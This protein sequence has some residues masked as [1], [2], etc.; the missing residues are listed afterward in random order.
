M[1]LDVVTAKWTGM[2]GGPGTST[3]YLDHA[4][5]WTLAPVGDFFGLLTALIPSTCTITMA[6][7][8]PEIDPVTGNLIGAWV[9]AAT[10]PKVGTHTGEYAS[11][12]GASVRWETG[13]IAHGHRVRGRTYLVPLASAVF[14]IDGSID[15]ASLATIKNSAVTMLA[16]LPNMVKVWHRPKTLP[17]PRPGSSHQVSTAAV[18]DRCAILRSRRG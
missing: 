2:P 8:G 9:R 7:E 5:A 12:I 17:V 15:A 1:G 3:F 6:T 11:G 14:D 18:P 16:G 13:D 10:T 4:L